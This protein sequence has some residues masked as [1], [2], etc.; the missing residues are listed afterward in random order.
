ML[1]PR[2]G[3]DF[4]R[5]RIHHDDAAARAADTMR[6]HAFTRGRQ[7]VLG[8]GGHRPET[9]EGLRLLAHELA[10]VV[11]QGSPPT[12]TGG[13]R[14][15]PGAESLEREADRAADLALAGR[16]VP[17]GMLTAA[18]AVLQRKEKSKAAE[19]AEERHRAIQKHVYDWLEPD[20]VWDVARRGGPSPKSLTPEEKAK[21]PHVLFNNSA[22]WIRSGKVTLSVLTPIP[23]QKAD[24]NPVLVFDPAVRHPALGGSVDNTKEVPSDLAAM[25]DHPANHLDLIVKPDLTRDALRELVRHEIQHFADAHLDPE[26]MKQERAEF[27]AEPNVAATHALMNATIW[28]QYQTEFRGYWLGSITRPGFQAGVRDDGTVVEMGGSGGVDRWGSE[29]SPGGELKVSGH[30]YVKDRPTYVPEASVQLQNEKQ[31]NIAR[32]IVGKYFGMAETFLTSPLFR[33]KVQAL[34][35]PQGVNLV[36]SMRIERLRAALQ[37]P[38]TRR[39]IGLLTRTRE[40]DVAFFVEML[41]DADRAFLKSASAKPFW[42]VAQRVLSAEMFAWMQDNVLHGKTKIPAPLPATK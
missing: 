12:S 39:S 9:T 27:T 4:S 19:D 18:P 32:H 23:G 5:V 28:N 40:Q 24:A 10:H 11:Q 17:R 30:D 35:R 21:D 16:T 6:A 42:D 26:T 1:E 31:T 2:L 20:T 41:D 29:T 37:G 33:Q 36:N 22:A 3:H 34:D 13:A 7:V 15:D 38:A 25:A 8:R 14:S